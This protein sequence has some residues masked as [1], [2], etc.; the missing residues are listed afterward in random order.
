[1]IAVRQSADTDRRH[2]PETYVVE[3]SIIVGGSRERLRSGHIGTR[4]LPLPTRPAIR[5]P[6]D[7]RDENILSPPY[8]VNWARPRRSLPHD[9][10]CRRRRVRRVFTT[11]AAQHTATRILNISTVTHIWHPL[12]SAARCPWAARCRALRTEQFFYYYL[13]QSFER[14]NSHVDYE[15]TG[16]VRFLR[17]CVFEANHQILKLCVGTR[18]MIRW[19][20]ETYIIYYIIMNQWK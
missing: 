5:S 12:R 7:L 1:M 18:Y 13:F 6:F 2:Q 11:V 14:S 15:T 10:C 19:R 4:R 3:G 20:F 17:L 8:A 9:S 16:F